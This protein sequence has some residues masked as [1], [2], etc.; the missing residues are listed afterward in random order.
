[1]GWFDI[2]RMFLIAGGALAAIFFPFYYHFTARWWESR[3][4]RYIMMGG[5]GWASLYGTGII[6]LFLR[7]WGWQEEVRIFLMFFA[8]A[9]AWVQLWTYNK[10]RRIEMAKRRSLR[11][12]IHDDSEGE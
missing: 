4:G 8:F 1:M 10:V 7:E 11:R 9:F 5:L 12:T 6:G 3:E 2:L